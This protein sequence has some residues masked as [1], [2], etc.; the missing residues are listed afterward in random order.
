MKILLLLLI[1][2]LSTEA[3]WQLTRVPEEETPT[4]AS[5]VLVSGDWQCQDAFGCDAR[6]TEGGEVKTVH[7]RN[8]D[9]VSE[10]GGWVVSPEDGWVKLRNPIP[11]PKEPYK[12]APKKPWWRFW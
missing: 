2:A 10:E 11:T 12:L 9:I 1:G 8:G 7:F 6:I 3:A 4:T 5:V